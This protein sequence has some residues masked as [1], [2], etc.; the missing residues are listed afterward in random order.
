MVHINR[1][2][3]CDGHW[4]K[5]RHTTAGRVLAGTLVVVAGAVLLAKQL[6]VEMPEWLFTW[7][8]LLILIG[9]YSG[10]R[11]LF[12][13]PSWV[14]LVGIG[15]VFLYDQCNPD[16]NLATLIWP[17]IIILI[18]LLMILK[19]RK[20][21]HMPHW[22]RHGHFASKAYHARHGDYTQHEKFEKQQAETENGDRIEAIAVFGGVKKNIISKQFKGGEVTCIMGGAE[23]NLMQA[24][25]EGRV[26][27]EVTQVL[28]GTKLII[29]AHWDVQPELTAA[30]LGGIEDKRKMHAGPISDKVLVLKG[31]SVLGGIEITSY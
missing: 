28:G 27:L 14:I 30:V 29:P 8:M 25:I 17:S 1:D 11:H 6:G 4:K 23:I 3:Y 26:E 12:C 31:T 18:G 20:P 16:I 7:P 24:D 19:S 2:E 13:N 21:K 9:L 22:G 5:Y 15:G 10:A